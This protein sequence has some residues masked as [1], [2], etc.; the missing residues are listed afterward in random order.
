MPG[1]RICAWCGT[2][3]ER[4]VPELRGPSH[5]IC[6]PCERVYFPGVRPL[7]DELAANPDAPYGLTTNVGAINVDMAEWAR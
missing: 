4:D 1:T 2:I 5:G 6:S 3:L 7:N